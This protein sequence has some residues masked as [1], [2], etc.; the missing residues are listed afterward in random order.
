MNKLKRLLLL[1]IFLT[2]SFAVSQNDSI[3]VKKISKHEYIE[4]CFD[5]KTHRLKICSDFP[6][7]PF[8]SQFHTKYDELETLFYFKDT[9]GNPTYDF[10]SIYKYRNVGGGENL[11][12]EYRYYYKDN[13]EAPGSLYVLFNDKG[14]LLETGEIKLNDTAKINFWKTTYDKNGNIS[15]QI[16]YKNRDTIGESHDY[17][18]LQFY[19]DSNKNYLGYACMDSK[20]KLMNNSNGFAYQAF[21]YNSGNRI[22]Q[23]AWYDKDSSLTY[24]HRYQSNYVRIVFEY[25]HKKRISEIKLYS[26][27]NELGYGLIDSDLIYMYKWGK[28]RRD[29]YTV[30]SRKVYK[31]NALGQIVLEEYYDR[32]SQKI[33]YSTYKYFLG[34][35]TGCSSRP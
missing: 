18:I 15:N 21:S 11:S 30:F 8:V 26:K 7:G 14:W 25:D 28:C 5:A 9:L 23:M 1:F 16:Y 2:P 3:Y 4:Q 24:A 32:Y 29:M 33:A 6:L 13:I 27:G 12:A 22:S 17:S 34:F 31:Y 35:R 20:G 10:D 19:Y